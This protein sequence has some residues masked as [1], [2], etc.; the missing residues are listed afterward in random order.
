MLVSMRTLA[1][2]VVIMVPQIVVA[3]LLEQLSPLLPLSA[4]Q[5]HP[6]L[7]LTANALLEPMELKY[8]TA[9]D[10]K[11]L[12]RPTSTMLLLQVATASQ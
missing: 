2:A 8:A 12:L 9:P 1:F 4:L 10:S 5:Q 6:F 11:V 3:V 7:F